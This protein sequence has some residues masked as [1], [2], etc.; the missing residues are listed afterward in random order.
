MSELNRIVGYPAGAGELVSVE[1]KSTHLASSGVSKEKTFFFSFR[2]LLN[3]DN[4]S[5]SD[6][7]DEEFEEYLSCLGEV[8]CRV[9]SHLSP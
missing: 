6:R 8:V 5:E 4:D 7:F 3:T 1:K 9:P 2:I